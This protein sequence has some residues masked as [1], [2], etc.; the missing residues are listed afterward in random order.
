MSFFEEMMQAVERGTARGWI[1][2]PL[3][4]PT[5]EGKSPGKRPLQKGWQKLKKTPA[6]IEKWIGKGC[7]IGLVCGKTSNVTII[8]YDHDLFLGELL[9]GIEIETLMSSRIP[10]RGHIYFR[11]TEKIHAQK[12]HILGVEILSDGSNAVLPPSTHESGEKYKWNNPDAPIIEMPATINNNFTKLFE[13]EKK[14]NSLIG[15][16]RPCFKR[17]WKD[18]TKI[19]H[20]S[21]A[22]LFL[23]AFCSE[24]TNQGADL[25]IVKMFA[26]II[27]QKDYEERKTESEFNGWT[28]KKYKPWTCEKIREQCVGFADCDNCKISR[29]DENGNNGNGKSYNQ[30]SDLIRYSRLPGIELF[31]DEKKE[32]YARLPID[33]N[34]MIVPVGG[35]EFRRWLTRS[36]FADTGTAP[37]SD[38]LA[39][40]LGVIEA[41]ACY[42]GK[43]YEL[44]NRV[45]SHDGA[46][47]YDLGAGEAVKISAGSWEIVKDAPILFR[48]QTH[49]KAHDIGRIRQGGDLEKILD[50]IN[51]QSESERL[52]F[53][54]YLVSCFVPEIPHPI[55]V[56]YGDKGSSKTT[57]L[58]IIKAV[59]DP[60]VLEIISFPHNNTELVQKLYHHYFAPFDNIADL[61]ESQ[62]DALC[63]ACTGEGVSKRA[64]FTNEEDVIFNYKRCVALNGVNLVADKPDLLDRAILLRMDR[65]TK[66]KRKTED[67]VWKDFNKI[68]G[69]ILGGIFDILARAAALKPNIHLDELPRMADFMEWGCAIS[70]ALGTGMEAFK[71]AYLA[72]IRSQNTEA[73]DAS[74]VGDA[75]MKFVDDGFTIVNEGFLDVEKAT[76][77]KGTAAELLAILEECATSHKI[78]IKT[79]TW[80]K[81]GNILTRRL[82]EIKTNLADEGIMF[83]VVKDRKNNVL[84][85]RQLQGNTSTT[86]T[87]PQP[88]SEEPENC[89]DTQKTNLHNTS[90]QKPC[91]G[92]DDFCGG[93][94]SMKTNIPPHQEQDAAP[95]CGGCGGISPPIRGGGEGSDSC[96]I[97]GNPLSGDIEFYGHGLGSV[98]K[99]C[100]NSELAPQVLQSR[101]R[102][103]KAQWEELNNITLSNINVVAFAVWFCDTHQPTL[104]NPTGIRA[105]AEKLFR[106]TPGV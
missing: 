80:P 42:Y 59:V 72:N 10:G 76:S 19:R 50:F 29:A 104:I 78:N 101:L 67:K 64:L 87:P 54:V 66:E 85:L 32:P 27:Y 94:K 77:W 73:I 22:R 89:G 16:C 24:L 57:A 48:R 8:D 55:P 13:K 61:S 26:K 7:N 62:S 28:E 102:K 81:A 49:Q 1:I 97:C 65:I 40:A 88:I 37:G 9:S 41:V 69:D 106:I 25:D 11:Y 14:L 70:E 31:H 52:L 83:E 86:S 36:F 20:G 82:N 2:H 92:I 45:A 53:L 5:D 30:A 38:A 47:W 74:P 56:L 39:G 90:T 99:K 12:H 43:E 105:I 91:G 51:V 34:N 17:Y 21:T 79:K 58:K 63:R 15:K 35:R 3:S 23:G 93:S 95:S 33:G 46:I 103:A 6:D 84:S 18:E 75:L 44:F 100:L 96:G 60:S 4:K 68:K 98:H 71:G